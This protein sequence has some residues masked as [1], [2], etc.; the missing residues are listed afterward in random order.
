M[1]RSDGKRVTFWDEVPIYERRVV[2]VKLDN[3]R[4]QSKI[5]DAAVKIFEDPGIQESQHIF[6]H[7]RTSKLGFRKMAD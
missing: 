3:N 1:T 5:L 6:F 2:R 7:Q 4:V